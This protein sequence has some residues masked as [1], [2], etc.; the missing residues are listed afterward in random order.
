M[1]IAFFLF[2]TLLVQR[3]SVLAD[4]KP[5]DPQANGLHTAK[6][7]AGDQ[8]TTTTTANCRY[9][10]TTSE[11]EA[12]EIPTLGA[13]SFLKFSSPIWGGPMPAKDAEFVHVFKVFQERDQYGNYLPDYRTV[14]PLDQSF[15]NYIK[16]NPGDLWL[17]GNEVDRGPNPGDLYGGQGDMYP[18]IYAVAYHEVRLFILAQDPT[19]RIAISGLVQVTPGRLQ[20]LTRVWNAYQARYDAPMPVDVWNIHLYVLPELE[21]DGK[22]N[23]LANIA[24]GTDPAL[25]KRSS[26]NDPNQCPN[27][28]VYCYAEHDSMVV[29]AEQVVAMRQWMK[30]H[31]E[32]QKPLILSEYSI[33]Y[34]YVVEDDSC[35]LQDE[36]GN[37]FTP[38][39]VSTFMDNTFAYMNNHRDEN[40]GYALDGNRLIQQWIWFSMYQDSETVGN[41]SN[42]V[43][44]NLTTL[45]TIGQNFKHAVDNEP[46]VVNLIVEDVP[47]VVAT[48]DQSVS[49]T[50]NLSVFFRNNGNRAIEQPFTVTFYKDEART[51]EIGSTIVSSQVSGCATSTYRASVVWTG[52]PLGKHRFWVTVDSGHA[53]VEGPNY[54]AD[55]VGDGLVT[56]TKYGVR[57]PVIFRK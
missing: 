48:I 47:D 45:T 2:T 27:N 29:F 19:A 17:I 21:P 22:P 43:E 50:A 8:E 4:S 40:L 55:N 57:L 25:G 1:G 6:R 54:K 24:L 38:A 42:L 32:Q 15:A 12:G 30:N 33:L 10:V 39:R 16:A 34:P 26:D 31:G 13:G 11:A 44:Q 46:P 20:Y 3:S 35:F 14:I 23:G 52:L 51:I 53:I 49:A 36:F 37:C 7:E 9:G 18:D 28:D 56:V 41:V 5:N